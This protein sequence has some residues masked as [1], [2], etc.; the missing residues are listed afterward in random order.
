MI[1][2]L[3]GKTVFEYLAGEAKLGR[4]FN[5]AMTNLSEFSIAP[6]TA[7]YDFSTFATIVDVVAATVGCWP[8]FSGSEFA[9]RAVRSPG[10]GGVRSRV[11]AR[12][13][14]P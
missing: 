8:P 11:V 10:G 4:I 6:L 3:R 5:S 9:R 7:A 13:R 14:C 1:P 12:E 2:E